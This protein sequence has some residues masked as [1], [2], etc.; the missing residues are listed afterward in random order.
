MHQ[1]VII[2]AKYFIIFSVLLAFWT[3]VDQPPKKKKEFLIIGLIGAV[4]T[5]ILARLGGHFYYDPRPF[6]VGHFKP[7]F[8]HAP[9]N[10]FPSDHT[11]LASF[12]M[13]LCIRYSKRFGAALFLLAI[14]IGLARVQAGVHHM[15]DILGSF[16]CS[17]VGVL[18][19]LYITERINNRANT[20]YTNPA[21]KP[22]SK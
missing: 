21:H 11:L 7:Y 16:V 5:V 20:T 15:I 18:L 4:L 13:F 8:Y 1:A 19:A 12:L 10:G 22:Q 9:D 2:V 3:F 6:V 17:G 14:A